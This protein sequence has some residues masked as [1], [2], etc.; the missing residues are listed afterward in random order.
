MKIRTDR[1]SKKEVEVSSVK[2]VLNKDEEFSISLNNFN[3]LVINKI[4]FG[5]GDGAITIKPSVSNEI[6]IS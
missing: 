1:N 2:V 3:E 6:R 5:S 4:Q